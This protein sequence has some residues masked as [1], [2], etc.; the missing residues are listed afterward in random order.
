MGMWIPLAFG[1]RFSS[2]A[3]SL[4]GPNCRRAWEAGF[5]GYG[6]DGPGF[7]I[8]DFDGIDVKGKVWCF[9]P[10]VRMDCRSI[11]VSHF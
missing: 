2:Y 6:V 3:P 11:L 4:D 7:F 8:S 5:R 1:A 10:S 9:S